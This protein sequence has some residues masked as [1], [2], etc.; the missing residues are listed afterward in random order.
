MPPVEAALAGACPV[1]SDIP[2]T[3][4]VMAGAGCSFLNDSYDSFADAMKKA[5][6]A[7][8]KE[9]SDWADQLVAAS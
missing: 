6:T 2:V 7:T 5:R 4:E 1:Y 9:I 3:R 8:P